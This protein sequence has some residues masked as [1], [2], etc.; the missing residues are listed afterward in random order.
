MEPLCYR[1]PDLS[2]VLGVGRTHIYQLINAGELVRIK[3]A[4]RTLV[5][6]ASVE[7][8]VER[9]LSAAFGAEVR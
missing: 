8:Y 4:G 7:A 6:R 5:T 2:I 3:S 1:I 9:R